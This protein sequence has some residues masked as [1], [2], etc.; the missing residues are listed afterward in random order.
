MNKGIEVDLI[1]IE[2]VLGQ[3]RRVIQT[4]LISAFLCLFDGF[5]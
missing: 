4:P 3:T 5:N 2:R 1:G